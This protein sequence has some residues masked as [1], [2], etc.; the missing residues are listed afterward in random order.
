MFRQLKKV[1]PRQIK[2]PFR[3]LADRLLRQ[4]EF[5]E[6]Q[7]RSDLI[8]QAFITLGF[9]AI[10]GDYLEFGSATATT[11][12][13]AARASKRDRHM[14]RKLWAFDSF[15]GLPLAEGPEDEHPRWL[16]GTMKTGIEEFKSICRSA[17]ITNYGIVPGFY[18][19]TLR[20]KSNE[21]FPEKSI[22]F[23][24]VDCDMYSSTLEVLRFILPRL[25]HGMI[26]AFDD[27]WCYS[28]ENLSGERKAF[29]EI[30]KPSDQ[31]HFEPYIQFGWSGM[32]FV[33]EKKNLLP[34]SN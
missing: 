5:F 3:I 19:E 8:H 2:K 27:Y 31:W 28:T 30:L 26:I 21:F 25:R 23:V 29:L 18:S 1:I 7:A 24:Y 6:R 4:G 11:F 16:A 14:E 17:N 22:A 33:V 34:I 15:A 13:Y 9:N 10:E 12:I 32:S 20:N